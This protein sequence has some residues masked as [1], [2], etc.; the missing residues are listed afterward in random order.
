MTTLILT[1]IPDPD[2][3]AAVTTDKLPLI[4]MD[5]HVVDRAA[6]VVIPLDGPGLDVPDLD[7]AVLG[8]GDHPFGVD[9]EGD[10]GDVV[11]VALEG[12]E[13]LGAV[14]G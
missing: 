7:G 2:I 11:G 3:T 8:G 9:V 5:D 13:G 4:R 1:Q 10:A 6:V 14:L 12:E